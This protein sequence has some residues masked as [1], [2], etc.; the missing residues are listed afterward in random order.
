MHNPLND[1]D[2]QPQ[3]SDAQKQHF[4]K[5]DHLIHKVF[6]QTEEGKELLEYWKEALLISPTAEHGY[7]MLS[8]GLN[9]GKKTFI[10]N[11]LLTIKKVENDGP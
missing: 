8:V 2:V 9:E 5:L 4:E 11:I 7:D 3:W 6:A 1:L 10:R